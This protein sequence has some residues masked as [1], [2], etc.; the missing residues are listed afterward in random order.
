MRDGAVIKQF[1]DQERR[2]ERK[3][4]AKGVQDWKQEGNKGA[5]RKG[6][7]REPEI[8]KKR[9][10]KSLAIK[11]DSIFQIKEMKEAMWGK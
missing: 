1:W 7:R 9:K 8:V 3:R 5:F 2:N 10:G 4:G 11:Q 6:E